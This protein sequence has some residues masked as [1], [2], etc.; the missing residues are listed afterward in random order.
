MHNC[1]VSWAHF[2]V[3]PPLQGYVYIPQAPDRYLLFSFFCAIVLYQSAMDQLVPDASG[4]HTG[5]WPC[6][7]RWST[8][9]PLSRYLRWLTFSR[10]YPGQRFYAET[11]KTEQLPVC[12]CGRAFRKYLISLFVAWFYLHN[13]VT[14][15]ARASCPSMSHVCASSHP[16]SS[17]IWWG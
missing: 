15:Q 16:S 5:K 14:Q 1:E 7:A 2:S 3:S 13:C 6:Y 9:Q 10:L 4:C 8:E 17:P 12:Q 11:S